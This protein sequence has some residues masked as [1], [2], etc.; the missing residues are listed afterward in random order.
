MRLHNYL[1]MVFIG[2]LTASTMAWSGEL[3][4][5]WQEYDDDTGKVVALIRI[6]K[7]PDNTYEGTI[8]KVLS[9]DTD[10]NAEFICRLCPGTLRNHSLLGLR[11]L[12]GMKRKGN[13]NFEGGEVLDPDDGKTY[14]CR[15][16]LADDGNSLEVTGY[17][18]INWIGHSEIWRLANQKQNK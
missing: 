14:R 10:E 8:E 11:I 1:W 9:T 13:L 5:L 17:I 3:A 2:L 12:S 7:L 4:G 18:S 6:E 15:I 16:H